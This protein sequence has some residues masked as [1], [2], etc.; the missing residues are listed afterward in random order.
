MNGSIAWSWLKGQRRRRKK[1]STLLQAIISTV[2][3]RLVHQNEIICYRKQTMKLTCFKDTG[4]VSLPQNS[5]LF[6]IS[7]H[8]FLQ[9]RHTAAHATTCFRAGH[10]LSL[11]SSLLMTS[12]SN[13]R[14]KLAQQLF[15]TTKDWSCKSCMDPWDFP[16][17]WPVSLTSKLLI[18]KLPKLPL[19]SRTMLRNDILHLNPR[20]R[21]IY[22]VMDYIWP[23]WA[24]SCQCHKRKVSLQHY[25]LWRLSLF[26]IF[27]FTPIT[28]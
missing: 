26:F 27:S 3:N 5:G 9:D 18:D 11:S 2:S 7:L 1:I 16:L 23:L 20:N 12:Y 24:Y 22:I 8:I 28:R 6:T 17:W 15:W 13:S 19:T 4:N 10:I 14:G 25:H 21:S